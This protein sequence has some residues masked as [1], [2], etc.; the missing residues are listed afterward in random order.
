MFKIIN[1]NKNIKFEINK[2][3][4]YNFSTKSESPDDVNY[5]DFQNLENLTVKELKSIAKKHDINLKGK[6]V[7]LDIK[8]TIKTFFLTKNISS[9]LEVIAPKFPIVSDSKARINISLWFRD[10]RR[11]TG[12]NRLKRFLDSR[13]TKRLRDEICDRE[14]LTKDDVICKT[15]DGV[16]VKL[17][18]VLLA[19]SYLDDA[20]YYD[21]H[22]FYLIAKP[23]E[24][25][26]EV[27]REAV[28]MMIELGVKINQ[29]IKWDKFKISFAY[30][31]IEIN[32][33]VKGGLVGEKEELKGENLD[34]RLATHRST[35]ARFKLV[36]I[37]RFRDSSTVKLFE[38][39]MKHVLSLYNIGK[40]DNSKM[41]Q[42]ECPGEDTSLIVNDLASKQFK[43]MNFDSSELGTECP[44]EHI[45]NYNSNSLKRVGTTIEVD[46]ENKV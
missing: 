23:A 7:K 9:D 6:K 42:Y 34:L 5:L 31:L 26:K 45:D 4:K 14:C 36:N 30:Y 37:F 8:Q 29:P 38:Q 32:N 19:A 12:H 10:D 41:E 33:I 46:F 11:S 24:I 22:D 1:L 40:V 15:K 20:L 13:E 17:H 3:K 25:K 35:Y 39:T 44:R 27:R 43:L 18:L 16:F 28:S 2:K 21:I